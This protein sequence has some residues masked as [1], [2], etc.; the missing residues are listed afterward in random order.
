MASASFLPALPL[1][2]QDAVQGGGGDPQPLRDGNPVRYSTHRIVEHGNAHSKDAFTTEE[3]CNIWTLEVSK[4]RDFAILACATGMR[5]QELLALRGDDIAAGGMSITISRAVNMDGNVPVIGQTKSGDSNR[6]I[7]IP[8]NVQHIA[9]KYRDYGG[10]L[11]WQ[12]PQKS[13]RPIN[14]STYRAAFERLCKS[15]GVRCLTPHCCRHTYITQLHA[16]GVDMTVIKALAG[17]SRR[18]VTE[19]YTHLS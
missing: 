18:D 12:S 15:A 3:I 14:P 10:D 11:I 17:H 5:A 9:A 8:A 4:Q 2:H 19:G 7:P 1:D 16:H 6:V 13:D